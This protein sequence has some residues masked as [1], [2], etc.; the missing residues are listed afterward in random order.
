[1]RAG[2]VFLSLTVCACGGAAASKPAVPHAQ[3]A[4][5]PTDGAPAVKKP[6]TRRAKLHY[7]LNGRSFPL[8]V[9]H[10]TVAGHP[11]WMLIDT[12]AN[13]HVIAGWFAKKV[14]LPMYKLGDVG[15][16]HAGRAIATFRVDHPK[17]ALDDWG[18][19]EDGPMLVT[20][21]PAII[22]KLGIGAFV[23][24]QKLNEEGDAVVLDLV[25]HEV[26][27]AWFDDATRAQGTKLLDAGARVCED[28]QSPI[29]GLAY[30][31]PANVA[32]SP[33][34]LLVDTGAQRS[35]ILAGST[36]GKK[37]APSSVANKEQMYGAS[38]KLTSRTIPN[39]TV[40]VGDVERQLDVD[41]IGGESD[42]YCPRD[43]VLS[44]DVLR[45]CVL[46]LGRRQI[47]ARCTTPFT[48]EL[49]H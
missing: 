29:K 38:G 10:G 8:P 33:A 49:K 17:L 24:P 4:A 30:V 6:L 15:T 25:A 13:S 18:E 19:L 34:W 39:A 12:G 27:S 36:P 20:E 28:T 11:T 46:V 26:R 5:S 35:D 37:L 40:V 16:D 43:G 44:M 41:L 42:P 21:V 23:S 7:E 22:E 31:A 3:L 47:S 14:G 1:V 45:G 48:T 2:L 32:G 9:V